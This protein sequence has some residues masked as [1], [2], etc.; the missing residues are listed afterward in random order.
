MNVNNEQNAFINNI[1][2]VLS[3]YLKFNNWKWIIPKLFYTIQC[4]CWNNL[5]KRKKGLYL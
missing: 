2:Y 1:L 3:F 5:I 4:W